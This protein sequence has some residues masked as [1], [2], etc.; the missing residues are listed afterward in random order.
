MRIIGLFL[1]AGLFNGLRSQSVEKPAFVINPGHEFICYASDEV[2]MIFIPPPGEFLM[3]SKSGNAQIEVSYVGFSDEARAA[4]QHAVNIWSSLLRSDT[5]IRVRAL[6]TSMEPDVLG[7][8]SATSFYL[9][10]FIDARRADAYY[11][12]ALAEKIAGRELNAG[13][14][15]DITVRFNSEINWFYGLSGGTPSTSYDLVTVVLHELCHGLGFADS[16]NATSTQGSYGF[17]GFPV[18]YDTFIEGS[19][20][21]KLTDRSVYINPSNDLRLALTSG[22]LYFAAPVTLKYKSGVKPLIYA[23]GVF[24]SGSSVSHLSESGTPQIDALMTPF[25][26]KGEAI[27]DPG[28]LTLSMLADLGWIN[29]R[30]IHNPAK[31]TESNIS[32]VELTVDMQSDTIL[33][34]N[35]LKLIYKYDN[36]PVYDTVSLNIAGYDGTAAYTLPIPSYNTLVKYYYSAIDTFGRA[37]QL[38]SAGRTKPYTFYVGTD[39]VKPV[40]VHTPGPFILTVL[41][42]LKIEAVISDNLYPVTAK[43]RYNLNGG[44]EM[45]IIMEN[46]GQN[47]FSGDILLKNLALTGVDTIYY[48]IQATDQ[49]NNP[50]TAISP[51][52]GFHK[53]P[54]VSLFDAVD[55]YFTAFNSGGG[56]F[57]LDG[58]TVEQPPGFANPALHSLH[59]YKS[60]EVPGGKI[61][62]QAILKYPVAVDQ[63]GLFISF[64]EIVLVEPGEPGFPFGTED[65]YDYVVVE[66]TRDGGRSWFPLA[67]GYDSSGNTL[68]LNTYNAA[69][70]DNNSTAIGGPALFVKRTISLDSP[71]IVN[72]NDTLV[73]RFRL[74]SDPYA[75]G[76]GWAVDDLFIK[77]LAVGAETIN[78]TGFS[79][80]PNPGDGRFRITMPSSGNQVN[81]ILVTNLTGSAVKRITLPAGQQSEFDISDFSPGI[82]FITIDSGTGRRSFRYVLTGK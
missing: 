24:D 66:A 61:E 1:L 36:S 17:N 10:S 26:G 28:M 52:S 32:S 16:F 82:Y 42:T 55:H 38:P 67:D 56:D 19:N 33:R 25:I 74:F 69:I 53:I 75:N 41:D 20:G 70:V 21:R 73:I 43:V 35:G 80:F 57:L 58:F 12:V 59:P 76:W 64:R 44:P 22:A 63:S 11:Q 23:P 37:Y 27:H 51:S 50:N 14:E 40:I 8:A 62:Y 47:S 65:F 49:A 45:E 60:P 68:W 2:R 54:V 4:F 72:E 3:N 7:S 71:G 34:K 30:L 39:T 77:G 81:S 9:G 48:M 46:P 29:T 31:D 15:F 78:D 18:I 79:I 13:T 6:W 5:K